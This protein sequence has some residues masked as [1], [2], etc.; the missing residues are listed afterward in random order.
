MKRQIN[1]NSSRKYNVFVSEG[2]ETKEI[3]IEVNG[4]LSPAED[5]YEFMYALNDQLDKVLD[6]RKGDAMYFR[7]IRDNKATKGIITRIQ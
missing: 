5:A 1:V 4:I 2:G 3:N 7:P 6:L